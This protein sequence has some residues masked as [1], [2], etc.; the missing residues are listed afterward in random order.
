MGKYA[1]IIVG[2]AGS[3]KSTYCEMIAQHLMTKGRSVHIVNLDPA[4][5]VFNYKPSIDIREL[6]SLTDVM[7]VREGVHLEENCISR[8]A[9]NLHTVAGDA[10]GT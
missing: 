10:S 2:P 6:V 4:A 3:G 5:E 1:Q 9:F 8:G 7:E